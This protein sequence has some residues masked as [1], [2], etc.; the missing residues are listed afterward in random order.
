MVAGTVTVKRRTTWP[1]GKL[2]L[3][4]AKQRSTGQPAFR[5]AGLNRL[6]TREQ[7]LARLME[8][9]WGA[10]PEES[11]RAYIES[12]DPAPLL[13]AIREPMEALLPAIEKV[14][15]EQYNESGS[16]AATE[17]RTHVVSAWR[18][19]GKAETNPSTVMARFRFDRASPTATQFAK[20]EA[21]KLV[22]E[23]TATSER[24]IRNVIHRAFNE[25][26]IPRSTISSVV[27]ILEDVAPGLKS[28]NQLAMFVSTGVNVNGLIPQYSNAVY[29]SMG[30]VAWDLSQQGIT[31][32]KALQIVTKKGNAYAKKLRRSRARMIART[33]VMTAQNRGRMEAYNQAAKAG[34]ID[35]VKARVQWSTA[36]IDA[37][38]TCVGMSGQTV[39]LNE[40]FSPVSEP[41]AHPNCRCT[42]RLLPNPDVHG[43]PRMAGAGRVGDPFSFV[44][45]PALGPRADF[46]PGSG[47]T[48][49]PPSPV[50]VTPVVPG[51]DPA[52]ASD[53]Y[54][55]ELLAG[56]HGDLI[57]EK[58]SDSLRDVGLGPFGE[59]AG[60]L[61]ET[62][63]FTALS[64]EAWL[65]YGPRGQ[66]GVLHG[67]ASLA[68]DLDSQFSE[69]RVLFEWLNKN[70][71][72]LVL[73]QKNMLTEGIPQGLSFSQL[74]KHSD[75]AFEPLIRS[76]LDL[77]PQTLGYAD[78]M[79]EARAI[80]MRIPGFGTFE[81]RM[82]YEYP[83][84]WMKL[85]E[86]AEVMHGAHQIYVPT[87]PDNI[88]DAMWQYVMSMDDDVASAI[89][90]GE[91]DLGLFARTEDDIKWLE[92]AMAGE[93]QSFK[94]P[95]GVE[96]EN[97]NISNWGTSVF[98]KPTGVSDEFWA[99]AV[100][101]VDDETY[102][103]WKAK[104]NAPNS[105]SPPVDQWYLE[106]PDRL[107][108]LTTLL[109]RPAGISDELWAR[110][111]MDNPFQPDIVD[112]KIA[113]GFT[114][115][116]ASST[117]KKLMTMPEGTGQGF[118]LD[119]AEELAIAERQALGP[120]ADQVGTIGSKKANEIKI[121]GLGQSWLTGGDV[122][123]TIKFENGLARLVNPNTS[124]DGILV[125]LGDAD[126]FASMIA[127]NASGGSEAFDQ[128]YNTIE[129][130]LI[131]MRNAEGTGTQYLPL[132]DEKVAGNLDK[133]VSQL[134]WE[135]GTGG[136]QL[137][138]DLMYSWFDDKKFK[139]FKIQTG[140][141]TRGVG[142]GQ[143]WLAKILGELDTP[144]KWQAFD[145]VL[146][147]AHPDVR[148][149]IDETLKF[150]KK[151]DDALPG[152][153]SESLGT[154]EAWNAFRAA[155]K[156]QAALFGSNPGNF[157]IAMQNSNFSFALN[158][159]LSTADT[160]EEAILPGMLN[161]YADGV[162]IGQSALVADDLMTLLDDEVLE[163]LIEDP[164]LTIKIGG[165]N[166]KRVFVDPETGKQYL[167][168]SEISEGAALM[169]Q[170]DGVEWGARL[171]QSTGALQKRLF[172][173]MGGANVQIVEMDGVTG[174]LQEF[175]GGELRMSKGTF[176]KGVNFA[177]MTEAQQVQMQKNMIFDYLISNYDAHDENFV[178]LF[179]YL[180]A[181]QLPVGIDKGQAFK[182][183]GRTVGGVDE[184]HSLSA[185]EFNPNF[186]NLARDPYTVMKQA[187]ING[188]IEWKF[189]AQSYDIRAFVD[190]VYKVAE[191]G[192]LDVLLRPYAE[193]WIA[194][195]KANNI[196]IPFRHADDMI[197]DIRT[198]WLNIGDEVKALDDMLEA[199][200]SFKPDAPEFVLKPDSDFKPTSL[201]W[202]DK[203][204]GHIGVG[205]GFKADLTS[206]QI[207]AIG[208]YQ[209]GPYISERLRTTYAHETWDAI[210]SS[211]KEVITALESAMAP[212]DE[213]VIL[214]R[215]LDHIFSY[216]GKLAFDATSPPVE[217][218]VLTD[219]GFQS[220]SVGKRAGFSGSKFQLHIR[221]PKGV[222]GVWSHGATDRFT[223]ELEM[224][225]ERGLRYYVTKVKKIQGQ[226]HLDVQVILPGTE[227]PGAPMIQIPAPTP[228]GTMMKG[229]L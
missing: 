97:V 90:S 170:A 12:R 209:S 184:A 160:L 89:A 143:T 7:G 23:I 104:I 22:T 61:D 135:S 219:F 148:L 83:Y 38:P 112:V 39:M 173:E 180:D 228:T 55:G 154:P 47:I 140:T 105:L 46:F 43:Q 35:P 129:N 195:A 79:L 3:S 165:Q 169:G 8:L 27:E 220:S 51:L 132:L 48:A 216:E 11:V 162:K 117:G 178:T 207:S 163:R 52:M 15:W 229:K 189:M 186:N 221:V 164:A 204:Y 64:D 81:D 187:A 80:A 182:H 107:Q 222:Q 205:D 188:D 60:V 177:E 208:N 59:L 136:E 25:Q 113:N 68:D 99:K 103:H 212:L 144:E 217:G 174:A 49:A 202:A 82:A 88:S 76:I 9:G 130:A 29:N 210:S 122:P 111:G 50:V 106:S 57:R 5:P 203:K 32:E 56:E 74:Y 66:G 72:Q 13:A 14:L 194:H 84:K 127:H 53:R 120:L 157:E 109:E 58:M 176:A 152:M 69:G 150:M 85:K 102:L 124:G 78:E 75:E 139:K 196:D 156:K 223:D 33:E 145:N 94:S 125:A 142:R 153:Y 36:P 20:T 91:L 28:P 31:G 214:H 92:S 168:K 19:V 118:V 95:T 141:G 155:T 70:E 137:W 159:V 215:G 73:L 175:M 30:K 172:G 40:N 192:D 200:G 166:K 93:K 218:L 63:D 179:K 183:L 2:R 126:D 54:L 42:T 41:P 71:D 1:N 138:S 96:Y 6:N 185:L 146:S 37:C 128:T 206:E 87:R 62:L 77:N 67:V 227:F 199:A 190:E 116:P 101:G 119:A 134:Y 115:N 225:L 198:R 158:E 34:L 161:A 86:N 108:K 123:I 10:I 45:P 121:F 65:T 26:V 191:S 167:L 213:N 18:K 201:S 226:W 100:R 114:G 197:A 131:S 4:L 147:H 133:F 17:V 110:F 211:N 98:E 151:M 224:T 44:H 21:A 193:E 16:I 24:S 149:W 181:D 171:D